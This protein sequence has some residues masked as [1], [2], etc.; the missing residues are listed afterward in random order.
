MAFTNHLHFEM[1]WKALFD[2]VFVVLGLLFVKQLI[3][4]HRRRARPLGPK[5]WP[6]IGNLLDMPNEKQHL[7]FCHWADQWGGIIY[8]KI[9]GQ[10]MIIINSLQ[11]ANDMLEKKSN[12]YSDRPLLEMAGEIVGFKDTLALS[13]Y[14]ERWRESRRMMHRIMG[15]RT[16]LEK[17]HPV[18]EL[19]TRRFLKCVLDQPDSAHLHNH[20]CSTAGALILGITHGY[21]TKEKDDPFID[22]ADETLINF[23]DLTV[24]GA[25]LVDIFPILRYVPDWFPGTAWKQDAAKFRETLHRAV[26]LPHEYVKQQLAAGIATTSFTSMY[27][28]DE[29]M[30]NE[31]E[32]LLKWLTASIVGGGADTTVSATY[33][34]FLLMTLHPEIQKK[35]Q[36]EIDAV[37]GK[38]RLPSLND[39]FSLPYIEAIM[40]EVMRWEPIGPTGLAHRLM[41]DDIQDRYLIPSGSI[42]VTNIWK[43]LHDEKVYKNPFKFHP[44]RFMATKTHTPEP[45][46]RMAFG[47]GRRICPGMQMA[48]ASMFIWFALS[49]FNISKAV[50]NGIVITPKVDYTDTTIRHPK[51]FKCSIT[52]RLEQAIALI[53]S[54]ELSQD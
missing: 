42:V 40:K 18:E 7:T 36:A 6:I 13:P 35:G 28:E 1:S 19:E 39:R 46:P 8:L 12:L 34:F 37:V 4:S 41:E 25:F 45:D 52:P 17:F 53:R 33:S 51:P 50:E 29:K 2:V 43:F 22:L 49:V 27:L 24:P 16:N 3:S 38:D 10:P 31:K 20:L 5:G 21:C 32:K 15:S 47:W 11:A 23:S 48:E 44:E 26:D 30:S 14:G 9:L 54:V